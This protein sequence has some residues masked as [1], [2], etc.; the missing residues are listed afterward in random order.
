[1]RK[2]TLEFIQSL[3]G[4]ELQVPE[5]CYTNWLKGKLLEAEYGTLTIQYLVREDMTNPAG[6]IHGGVMASLMDEV[7]GFTVST[8]DLETFYPTVDLKVDLIA[9]GKPGDVLRVV[10]KTMRKGKTL[11]N[12]QASVYNQD[13]LLLAYGSSNLVNSQKALKQ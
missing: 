2:L 13:D 5:H 3:K 1:M 11:V 12:I 10:S 7:I 6:I 4:K 8:L 9:G